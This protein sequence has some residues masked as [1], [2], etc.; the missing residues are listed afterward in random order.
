LAGTVKL[1]YLVS[2]P[3]QYQAPMLRRIAQEPGIDLTV[4]FLESYSLG[5]YRDPGFG[6]KVEWDVPLLEGYKS[7]FLKSGEKDDPRFARFLTDRSFT[8]VLWT[9]GYHTRP[10]LKAI[11]S[12]KRARIR[13]MI[14]SENQRACV[15]RDPG[16]RGAIKEQVV[17]QVLKR[18]DA[19][20]PIGT[21]NAAYYRSLGAHDGKMFQVPYAVE[22]ERFIGAARE[23]SAHREQ[24]RQE[25]GLQPGR[26]VI[27]YAH[28]FLKRKRARD[29]YE[30]FRLLTRRPRPYLLFIGDGEERAALQGKAQSEGEHD[31]HFLGFRNQTE[32]PR[33]YDLCDVFVL[34]SEKEQWGLAINEAMCAGRAIVVSDEVGCGP[35]LVKDDANGFVYRV[36]EVKELASCLDKTLW[37]RSRTEAMGEASLAIIGSWSYE[38]DVIG[39]RAAIAFVLKEQGE[40]GQS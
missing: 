32:L 10:L 14:R 35:D 27:L 23:A 38:E 3:I 34:P 9:H 7:L 1:S 36:G 25:L 4:L 21:L 39:L 31:V 16:I 24:L 20:L 22:N 26:P 6:Q 17:R 18:A 13:V 12:A 15:Q 8:D 2:H 29:L 19:L 40:N 11:S 5:A 33:F 28:K 37:D 30:A